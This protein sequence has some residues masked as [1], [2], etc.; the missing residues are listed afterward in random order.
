[1]MVFKSRSTPYLKN[2]KDLNF[3]KGEKVVYQRSNGEVDITIDSEIMTHDD[4]PGDKTGYE[5]I[6]HDNGK[7]EFAARIR[8]IRWKGKP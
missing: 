5:A 3:F 8:I 6:F 1:M 4:A 2:G 7:R